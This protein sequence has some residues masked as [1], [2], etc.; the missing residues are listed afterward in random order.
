MIPYIYIKNFSHF[1]PVPFHHPRPFPVS[2]QQVPSFF[3]LFVVCVPHW[4]LSVPCV[5]VV[6]WVESYLVKQ[7]KPTHGYATEEGHTP[8]LI[9]T[10]PAHIPLRGA[11]PD[12]PNIPQVFGWQFL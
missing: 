5:S 10:L 2:A 9:H 11:W 8:S 6:V 12:G 1:S 4:V 3:L 7:K